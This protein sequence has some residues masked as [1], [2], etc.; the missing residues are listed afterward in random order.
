MSDYEV[1]I[2]TKFGEFVIHFKDKEDLEKSYYKFW[3]LLILSKKRTD[4]ILLREPEKVVPGFEDLYTIGADGLIKLLKLPEAKRDILKLTL[5]LSS[6]PL[7]SAQLK[8]ITG[9][10]NPPAYMDKEF[11][12]NPDG[13]YIL[14]SEGRLDVINRII[15]SIRQLKEG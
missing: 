2:K 3:N 13:T 8:Q 5:F 14:S 15:P 1:R 10:S 6:T 9:I 4:A 7:N 12:A 11:I